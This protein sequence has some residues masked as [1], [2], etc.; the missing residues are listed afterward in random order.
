AMRTLDPQLPL[1]SLKE[2]A[3]FET[4]APERVVRLPAGTVIPV[5]M[6]VVG[7]VL[8]EENVAVLPLR[9]SRDVDLVVRGGKPDGVFRVQGGEWKK[10]LYNYRMR[11]F[12]LHSTLTPSGG[13]QAS[14]RIEIS[15][16]N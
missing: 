10:Y 14:V 12:D 1:M 5:R 6:E 13:P 3:Q 4:L 8:A 11:A 7:D 16:D 9:L 2:F 15:V